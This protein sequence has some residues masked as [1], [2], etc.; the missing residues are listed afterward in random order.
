VEGRTQPV[1]LDDEIDQ[2]PDEKSCLTSTGRHFTK[3]ELEQVL[4]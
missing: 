4:Q 1:D 3:V 2:D